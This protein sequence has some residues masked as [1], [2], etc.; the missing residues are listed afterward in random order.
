MKA[1]EVRALIA[2]PVAKAR[3]HIDAEIMK[4]VQ[5]ERNPTN[6]Y[7]L[8]SLNSSEAT[9]LNDELYA[10]GFSV[11]LT[12]VDVANIKG[13]GFS[14]IWHEKARTVRGPLASNTISDTG[15]IQPN[16]DRQ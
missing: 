16:G 9:R 7:V 3:L 1:H 6:V 5:R 4:V 14:I 2:D 8:L 15:P 12:E 10:D 11:I 13:Y